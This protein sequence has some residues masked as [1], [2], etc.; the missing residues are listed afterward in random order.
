MGIAIMDENDEER[1]LQ[2]ISEALLK[3]DKVDLGYIF[4]SLLE[5]LNIAVVT[6]EKLQPFEAR[7]FINKLARFIR[8]VLGY[9]C[10]INVKILQLSP[11]SV[12]YEII[13]RGRLIFCRNHIRRVMYEAEVI[14]KC[15]NF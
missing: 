11:V 6:S 2:T 10:K 5:E 1:I 14:S 8:K 15:T 3:F 4:G 12:Q 7:K 13:R 9:D